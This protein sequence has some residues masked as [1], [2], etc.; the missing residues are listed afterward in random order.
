MSEEDKAS[1][2]AAREHDR[3]L[4]AELEKKFGGLTDPNLASLR[5]FMKTMLSP[6]SEMQFDTIAEKTAYEKQ[7]NEI[8]DYLKSGNKGDSQ[9]A[10]V[11]IWQLH[12][13][14][15]AQKDPE[16]AKAV[17]FNDAVFSAGTFDNEV[18]MRGSPGKVTSGKY[19]DIFNDAASALF[20]P[21]GSARV[22]GGASQIL[23][24]QGNV[25]L[26]TRV[27][28]KL[29]GGGS[30]KLMGE[31]KLADE[32]RRQST[33]TDNAHVK[34]S[35]TPLAEAVDQ[36]L[37][38][39]PDEEEEEVLTG[40]TLYPILQNLP[41]KETGDIQRVGDKLIVTHLPFC[42]KVKHNGYEFEGGFPSKGKALKALDLIRLIAKE[43]D[44][45]IDAKVED[46]DA[47]RTLS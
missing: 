28:A 8:N 47:G 7:L 42:L 29:S 13:Q 24:S 6:A 2:I 45:T 34:E 36:A 30:R 3:V 33:T 41:P 27:T 32:G 46:Y 35:K 10:A 22:L 37:G 17:A 26:D 31:C 18:I 38:T 44:E 14:A 11:K 19:H 9:M 23:D 20:G 15:R 21:G 39:D 12:R 1:C 4:R 25:I 5:S 16:Y 40:S 43:Q